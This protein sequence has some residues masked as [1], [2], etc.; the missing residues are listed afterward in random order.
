[1]RL[2]AVSFACALAVSILLITL[3][4]YSV[5]TT[6]VIEDGASSNRRFVNEHRA[7]L[8]E[9]NGARA[10]APLAAPVLIALVPLLVPTRN[11]RVGAALLLGGFCIVGGFSIGLF[12]VPSAMTMMFA[13]LL[14]APSRAN[15]IP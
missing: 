4:M 15:R 14:G 2:T 10:L 11:V 5:G 6:E 3:P 12:Y 1:M 13:A 8:V 7:T 9:V